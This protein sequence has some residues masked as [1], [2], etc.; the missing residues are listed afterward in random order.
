MPPGTAAFISR[1]R[2]EVQVVPFSL[3]ADQSEQDAAQCPHPKKDRLK[4]RC[5]RCRTFVGFG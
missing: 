1:G 3:G 2:D 5:R 4:G